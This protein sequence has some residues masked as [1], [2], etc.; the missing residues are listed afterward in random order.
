[1]RRH[2]LFQS[3][4]V[5]II[6]GIGA[7]FAITRSAPLHPMSTGADEDTPRN[8]ILLIGDGM[9][10]S[11]LA[12]ASLLEYGPAGGFTIET[13]THIGLVRT[14]AADR[15]VTD[16]GASATAF[17]TG[18]KTAYYG[19]SMEPGGVV[20]RTLFEAAEGK[21]MATGVMTTTA[22][23]DATPAAFTAHAERRNELGSIIRQM[24]DSRTDVMFG[25]DGDLLA[26]AAAGRVDAAAIIDALRSPE[27]DDLLFVTSADAID[28]AGAGRVL[29]MF[30]RR[31][32]GGDSVYGPPLEELL[33][34]ALQRI[35]D[36][37]GGFI[38]MVECEETD[39]A[40]HANDT[41]RLVRG[42]KELD[43]AV[44]LALDF[45][46]ERGDTLVLVTADHDTGD[47]KII[48]DRTDRMKP[49]VEWTTTDHSAEWV[50]IFAYGPGATR[51]TGV[52]DN[53]NI[54]RRLG[55]LLDLPDFPKRIL[56]ESTDAS[57]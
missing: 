17:A 27:R 9:G 29:A 50:P 20:L 23:Y 51:F 8:V 14:S 12:A 49:I 4:I 40:G 54:A 56:P 34:L 48:A 25:G 45:A 30:P 2:S 39:S 5:F 52:I 37:P 15:L 38:L 28:A 43:R 10:L 16:S 55:A 24:A 19:I 35:G 32:P 22:L 57:K 6:I 33:I 44:K 3:L 31:E 18:Y 36:H 21:G 13:M 26:E 42:V 11:Q 46:E 7:M 1:M 41:E 47:A 53:T